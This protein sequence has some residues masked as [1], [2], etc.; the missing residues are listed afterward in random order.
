MYELDKLYIEGD[1]FLLKEGNVENWLKGKVSDI[2]I[3]G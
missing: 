1:L 3:D 2:M